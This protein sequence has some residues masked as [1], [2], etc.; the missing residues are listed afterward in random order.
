MNLLKP[1]KISIR[2]K[3]WCKQ[4][5]VYMKLKNILIRTTAIVAI[6]FVAISCDNDFSSVGSEVIGGV[7]FNDNSYA[8]F[9]IAYS[10]TFEKVQTSNLPNNLLGV[11]NDPVYGSSTYSILAQVDPERFNPVYGKNPKLDS[12]VFDLPYFSRVT[13]SETDDNGV[14]TNTYVLDSIYR[15]DSIKLS[16]YQSNFFLRDFEASDSGERKIYYSDEIDENVQMSAEGV[17]LK[18]IPAFLPSSKE[19]T[20]TTPDG[21]DEDTNPDVQR[22]APRLRFVLRPAEGDGSSM[23]ND[24]ELIDHF[25]ALFLDKEGDAEF[26][27]SNNFRNFFRGIYI[28]AESMLDTPNDGNLVF[29]GIGDASITLNYSFDTD[30]MD[31]DD[32]GDTTEIIRDQGSLALNFANNIVN[33]IEKGNNF[34]T[35]P[36]PDIENGDEDLFLKGGEGSYAVIDLFSRY[37]EVDSDGDFI[38]DENGNPI[39]IEN[40]SEEE[41]VK[42]ELDFIKSRDW[43]INDASIKLYINQNKVEGGDTEPER[44]YIFNQ[45]TGQVLADYLSDLQQGIPGILSHLERITRGSDDQGEF[46]KI[47]LTRHIINVLNEDINNAKLGIAVSQDVNII[48]NARGSTSA[49]ST[50]EELI[51]F[52]SITSHEGTILYG[53][54][55][56][57]PEAKRL[58]LDIF[59]TE[60]KK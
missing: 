8:A 19:I 2:Q 20:L 31:E 48:A 37:V 56:N 24:Q 3:Y 4:K 18:E 10:K 47:R 52:S 6:V 28:K 53:N 57:V 12:I 7:N 1:I 58:K 26:S 21:E 22:L 60:S 29:F 42:T 59:Y 38:V 32:D 44:I 11:Y 14:I 17:L 50:D 39:F 36:E 41:K 13:N 25:T 33:G 43:L 49:A 54:T 46:Y 23:Q 27:N 30:K 15:N 5:E 9:P 40:P 51:P 16:F 45:E 34:I 55:E 35:I